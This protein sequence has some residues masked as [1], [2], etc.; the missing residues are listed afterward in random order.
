MIIRHA[1]P[2]D[3]PAMAAILNQ[4]IAIGGTTAHQ[5]AKTV[6]A[7]RAD[8]VTGPKVLA[9]VVAEDQGQVIGWQSVE[10]WQDEG[11]IGTFVRPGLQAKGVGAALFALTCAAVRATEIRSI[12]AIIRKD[13]VPGLAYY[14]R[15]GFVDF[16]EDPDFALKDGTVV[17]RVHRRFSLV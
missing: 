6:D 2:E 9:S 1:T 16:A 12:V 13:N 8:Y 15:M 4:I 17:G 14:A 10:L 11:D 5:A 3:A 7:V